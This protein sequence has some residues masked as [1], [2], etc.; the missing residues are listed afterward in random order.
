MPCTGSTALTR[1]PRRHLCMSARQGS[2]ASPASWA[3]CL[4]HS[5]SDIITCSERPSLPREGESTPSDLK[6]HV[7]REQN[8]ERFLLL[9][10]E[11]GFLTHGL[12]LSWFLSRRFV[13]THH[14]WR[15][16]FPIIAH[17]CTEL[18]VCST[19]SLSLFSVIFMTVPTGKAGQELAPF[20]GC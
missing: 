8:N 16:S 9:L 1:V 11:E 4:S 10:S 15:V 5:A 19:F 17:T 20:S 18:Q 14:N 13:C 3:R 12:F 2:E 6:S 7:S